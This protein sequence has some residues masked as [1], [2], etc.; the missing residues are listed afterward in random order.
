MIVAFDTE[1]ALIRPGCTAPPIT[2]ITWQ[3]LGGQYPGPARI[4]SDL[5][6]MY[7][8]AKGWLTDPTVILVGHNVGYDLTVLGAEWPDLVPLIFAAYDAHR[9]TDTMLRQKLLD[10]AGGTYRGRHLDNGEYIKY[11]YSLESCCK[12]VTGRRLKKDGFRLFYASFRDRPIA[13]WPT[14]ALY[15]Q[16]EGRAWLKGERREDFTRHLAGDV[17]QKDV[18]GLIAANPSEV[19]SYPLEDATATL[20]LYQAQ[21]KHAA[22][23]LQNQWEQARGDWA[24]K[25]ISAW[26]LR[27]RPEG[28]AALRAATE[29]A[30][31]EVE[32]RLVD[33]GLVRKDGSRDTK[34]AKE[35][36]AEVC[37]Q[38]GIKPRRTATG[39][40][41]LDSD[42]CQSVDDDLLQDYAD[43]TSYT[44]VLSNDVRA[45]ELATV[46]PIHTRFDIA[47]TGRVTSCIAKGTPVQ[48]PCDRRI[49]PQGK[50]IEEIKAG[51]R[52]YSYSTDGTL[53]LQ[54][55][56]WAGC[57]GRKP[58][59]KLSWRGQGAK[60]SG[61]VRLTADHRV[62]TLDGRWVPAGDLKPGDRLT[63]L[64][65]RPKGEYQYLY[66]RGGRDHLEHIFAHAAV[67]GPYPVVH[68]VDHSVHNNELTNLQGL[69][70]Q[71]EHAALH[72]A[73]ASPETIAKC[74]AVLLRPDVQAKARAAVLRGTEHPMWK[75]MPRTTLLRWAAVCKGKI[76]RIMDLTGSDYNVLQR[77]Y[78]DAGIDLMAVR[79]RYNGVGQYITKRLVRRAAQLVGNERHKALHVSHGKF[80]Q[81]LD[82]H[83]LSGNHV[84]ID[85]APD[86]WEDVYDL[87]VEH[88]HSFV[89]GEICVHNSKPN[90]QNWRRLK[91]V[92]ECFV[93][94]PGKV[95]AQADY[96]ALELC[97]LAQVCLALLGESKLAEAL[98]QGLDPHTMLAARLHGCSYEE[99]LRLKESGD[100]AFDAKRQT[101]KVANFGFPGGLGIEK[102]V[103]FARKSYGVVITVEEARELKATWLAQWPEMRLY[104]AHVAQLTNNPDGAAFLE[105]LYV[106]R[107]RGGASYCAAC[108]SYFQGLG[109]DATKRAAYA[110][111][112]E[113]YTDRSSVLFGSRIVNYIHDEFILETDDGPRAHDVA[114]RLEAIMI[115]E[116]RT[117]LPDVQISA[118]PLLM[119]YW[120]KSAKAVKGPDGRLVPWAEA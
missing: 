82:V 26:G 31:D 42:A 65:C 14:W 90:V 104:F 73:E 108:N 95:F 39:E 37:A 4:E 54:R 43:L 71:S 12:R 113:C 99:G 41:S 98:N 118:P 112:K 52:V 87:E 22:E 13:T 30:R 77:K 16:D 75:D 92:R 106:K 76:R 85:V 34:K 56:L 9:I 46:Y 10:I 35:R 81:L 15:I 17:G 44:K 5:E 79:K 27:T 50:P 60:H 33:A 110:I 51:D 117:L 80:R 94:R 74:T 28:V 67:N 66:A 38:K 84:V 48:T 93:P 36:M 2:C 47:D 70:S 72:A 97:T 69:A 116:A 59:V 11:D 6:A 3:K 109:A 29:E 100:K 57:T 88:T 40:L 49:Y 105:Q 119:R 115:R 103:L 19:V 89:A 102:F 23:F 63:A 7:A 32:A 114:M 83:G 53:Y 20:E 25:L 55:V 96:G 78:Q 62:M 101:A 24:L 107:F 68:H 21:E 111:V 86:G 45:L 18:E 58:V 91:G 8:L 61:S 120:S 1:T 64:S